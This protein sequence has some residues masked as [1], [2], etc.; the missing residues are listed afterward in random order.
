MINHLT[1]QSNRIQM[2][3]SRLQSLFREILATLASIHHLFTQV[4]NEDGAPTTSFQRWILDESLLVIIPII[5]AH[6]SLKHSSLIRFRINRKIEMELQT[7]HYWPINNGWKERF[8][9]KQV[10]NKLTRATTASAMN[11]LN[12]TILKKVSN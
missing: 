11:A 7:P 8:I 2:I 5:L 10:P 6:F 4:H 1:S 12:D 3:T 9:F